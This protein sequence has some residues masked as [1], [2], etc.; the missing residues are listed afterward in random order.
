MNDETYIEGYHTQEFREGEMALDMPI[1][2]VDKK[3]WLGEGYYFWRD[4]EFAH[5][6][7]IDKKKNN[8]YYDIYCTEIDSEYLLDTVFNESDYEFFKNSID[9]AIK[10][11]K[12][13][14][15]D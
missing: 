14:R 15:N 12:T 10:K 4:I 3:A 7:G 8:G 1:L 6:W 13:D 11:I 2:C 5:Y 9:K